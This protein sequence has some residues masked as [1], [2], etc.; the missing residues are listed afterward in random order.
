V[1]RVATEG[2]KTSERSAPLPELPPSQFTELL[3]NPSPRLVEDIAKAIYDV[4]AAQWNDRHW[5]SP[6][7]EDRE[8]DVWREHF[9]AKARAAVRVLLAEVGT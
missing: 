1:A 9:R 4:D 5:P 2:R 7:W 8:V 3:T 6:A